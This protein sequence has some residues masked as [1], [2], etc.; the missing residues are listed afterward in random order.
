MRRPRISWKTVAVT[1]AV[2]VCALLIWVWRDP[3][4]LVRG[5]LARQRWMAGLSLHHAGVAGH[6][7]AYA[8]RGAKDPAAPTL[9]MIHGFT[10]S[11]EN[12]YPLAE[13]LVGQYRVVI[14][15]L[16]GWGA[17]ERK[18]GEDYGF[19]A[20]NR[21]LAE[22]I[23]R[24]ARRPGSPLVLLGHSMGGGIVA[25]TAADR[26]DLVDRVALIDAAGVRFRDNVFGEQV[27]AGHNPFAVHDEASLKRYLDTVFHREE[28]KPSIPWPASRG[29]IDWRRAQAPFEQAVLDR[30]GRGPEAFLP[31]Q[32]AAHVRQPTLLLWCAQDRVIDPSALELYAERI[33]QAVKV[34]LSD[35][36]HMSIMERPD[37]VAAAVDYLIRNGVPR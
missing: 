25:L 13:R 20:Q 23:A 24:V 4:V 16:P 18:A 7:W 26:P 33:P 28:A 3:M 15:D 21:R 31:G 22:F 17:S 6:R 34:R 10:G 12:W 35:C 8:E 19:D 2:F 9:V 29:L 36:G 14:P 27:L 11:K 32:A 30:I 5:E 37:D 1:A